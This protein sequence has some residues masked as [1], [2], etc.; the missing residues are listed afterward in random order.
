MQNV[1]I[2]EEQQLQDMLDWALAGQKTL[3][4]QGSG[5]K[6]PLGRPVEADAHLDL[7]G[8]SG[9]TLYEPAEL[10][11][12][13]KAGTK[14]VD[15]R[16]TLAENHQMLA[17]DPPDYG[18]LL[19]GAAGLAT[20]GG[21]FS[22]NLSGA[23]RVKAGSARDHLLG[24]TGF[25]GR[26]QAFQT[27]SRVMKN[28]TGYDLCKLV[29]GSYGTLAIASTVT[30]KVL[31]APE[32]IRT[33]LLYGAMLQD[34]VALMR[35]GLSSV[36]DVSAAAY[37]PADVA[38]RLSINQVCESGK[39]VLAMKIEGPGPSASFRTEEIRILLGAK[40]EVE[41]LDQENSD[42]FWRFVGDVSPFVGSEKPVWKLSLPPANAAAVVMAITEKT[43]ARMYLDWG[44]GLIWL[45]MTDAPDDGGAA[46]VRASLAGAGHATLIRGAEELRRRIAPF[47]PQALPIEKLN[48]RI[49][50][51]FDPE[52]ILNPGRMYP[53]DAR[54][55]GGD[56]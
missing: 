17:F 9:V 30:F 12:R 21:T 41:E 23:R 2:T 26:G 35:D 19:G 42:A 28:V 4:L 50:N 29:A 11:M 32:K 51:A 33:V 34:A 56:A 47:Q 55:A 5:S 25:T 52:H 48:V 3:S 36:H 20:L 37:L 44:G 45:E 13:A 46:I 31:P 53:L 27:G 40:G 6:T 16:K 43:P 8:L 49:K 22:C 39:P 38:A 7:S 24:V 18:P 15:I 54:G 1:T 10:V 14:L